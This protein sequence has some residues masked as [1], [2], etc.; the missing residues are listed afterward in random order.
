MNIVIDA[1][2]VL[3]T[4]VLL[5]WCIYDEMRDNGWVLRARRNRRP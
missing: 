5:T 3:V 2:L 1:V 4:A